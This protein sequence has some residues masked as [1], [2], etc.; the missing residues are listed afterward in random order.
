[1]HGRRRRRTKSCE[2]PIDFETLVAYWQ[3]EVPEK[4][5]AMLEEHFFGCAHCTRRLEG[6]VTL[7][8]GVRT[9]VKDGRVSM[10]ISA[11]F[12][13]AM[14]QAG[15]RL[16]E[17]S[18]E[19][20]GSVNC[21]IHADDGA[22]ASRLRAPLAGVE[23]LDLVRM[24]GGGESQERVAE[25]PFD[26]KTGEVLVIPSPAWLKTMPAF[27]MQMRLIAVGEAGERQ[28]GEYT[29]NYSPG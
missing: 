19:P 15:L 17:Y 2:T 11:P 16:R 1:V 29:F 22:V 5:E 4:R 25:V 26:V 9:A 12:V 13:E 27:T 10:V 20:G 7:A 6:L 21:T 3:G 23:R 24:R 28:I 18:V 8:S 14:E